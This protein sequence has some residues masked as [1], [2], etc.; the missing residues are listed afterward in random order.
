[1]RLVFLKKYNINKQL[2]RN[3]MTNTSLENIN[4][5]VRFLTNLNKSS[6]GHFAV[7]KQVDESTGEL[8]TIARAVAT[9]YGE[10]PRKFSVTS[11][12]IPTLSEGT[13][14]TLAGVEGAILR[15]QML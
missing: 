2:I 14:R 15:G 7:L 1:M 4:R 10:Y 6:V 3:N 11:S 12:K 8:Q 13:G 5:K 9:T